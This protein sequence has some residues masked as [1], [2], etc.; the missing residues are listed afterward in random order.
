MYLDRI[1]VT[2]QEEVAVLKSR[3]SV[4]E[5]EKAVAALPPTR[6]FAQAL[7]SGRSREMGLIAEVKKASPSKG[8]IRPDFDPVEIARSYEEA[9]ADCISVLTDVSY[10]QGRPEYLGQIRAEVKL[11]LLRKDFIIDELQIYEA[12]LLGA[13]A[14]LLIAAILDDRQLHDYFHLASSLG[15]DALV[16]V[17]DRQELERANKLDGVKLI[18]VNNRDLTTFETRLETTE[19]LAPYVKPGAALISESGIAGTPDIAYLAGCGAK[20]VLIGETFMRRESVT[21]AVLDVMGPRNSKPEG[22]R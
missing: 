20:G 4:K 3:L 17:H 18:G 7:L 6:G 19:R 5:A 16:E 1:V 10:F 21:Q 22:V 12:R 2:K 8:L 15:M 14:V 13:D 11:P 9:G